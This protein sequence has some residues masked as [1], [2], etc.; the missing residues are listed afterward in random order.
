MVWFKNEIPCLINWTG[1]YVSREIAVIT[2]IA[3]NKIDRDSLVVENKIFNKKIKKII[4]YFV[5]DATRSMKKYNKSNGSAIDDI[6]EN[7]SEDDEIEDIEPKDVK[8]ASAIYRNKKVK[9]NTHQ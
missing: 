8:F 1:K 9:R 5:L 4:L 7:L 3:N 2:R 6:I